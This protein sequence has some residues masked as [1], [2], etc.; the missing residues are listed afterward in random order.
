MQL[1]QSRLLNFLRRRFVIRRFGFPSPAIQVPREDVRF[2]HSSQIHCGYARGSL[3]ALRKNLLRCRFPLNGMGPAK[4]RIALRFVVP[5]IR[6]KILEV[7][8]FWAC[9]LL[10][11]VS[12]NCL[13]A[14]NPFSFYRK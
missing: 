6:G 8:R 13:G 10:P 3:R 4:R 7:D 14:G 12:S 5:G 11:V 9:P 1:N 2:A